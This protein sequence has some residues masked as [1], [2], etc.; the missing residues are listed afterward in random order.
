MK[1]TNDIREDYF[2]ALG[3]AKSV[4]Q[5]TLACEWARIELQQIGMKSRTEAY[6]IVLSWTMDYAELF[7]S[8]EKRHVHS[9]RAQDFV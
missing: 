2:G 7:L 3:V 9:T 5:M 4:F 8:K 6:M 1:T